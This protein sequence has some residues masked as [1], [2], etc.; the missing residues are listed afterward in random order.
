MFTHQ[1]TILPFRF[2]CKAF[3]SLFLAA[4]SF[5]FSGLPAKWHVRKE[6]N[7]E[8]KE[9]RNTKIIY[10]CIIKVVKETAD[11]WESDNYHHK[12]A[13]EVEV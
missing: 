11:R 2:S 9:Y 10:S 8:E 7:K 13:G 6:I 1:S 4:I 3:P 12:Q 5:H